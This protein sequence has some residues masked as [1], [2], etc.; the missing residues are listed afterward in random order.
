MLGGLPLKPVRVQAFPDLL[1][2]GGSGTMWLWGSTPR[3][4]LRRAA[5]EKAKKF[6]HHLVRKH[7]QI[8]MKTI[9]VYKSNEYAAAQDAMVALN[10]Q[11]AKVNPAFRFEIITMEVK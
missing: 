1:W 6:K 5:M 4:T 10:A 2:A 8:G 11:A 3:K 9:K 7:N